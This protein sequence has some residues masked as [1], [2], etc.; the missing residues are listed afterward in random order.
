MALFDDP[1]VEK[2][3]PHRLGEDLATLSIDELQAR[4]GLLE[5]EIGRLRAAI[6]AKD[7]SR[8]A[9]SAFFRKSPD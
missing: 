7:A 1:P 6:T 8:I 5:A 2:R 3:L 4:I 9:A